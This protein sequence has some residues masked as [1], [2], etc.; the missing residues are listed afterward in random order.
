MDTLEKVIDMQKEGIDDVEISIKLQNEG[1]SP[2]EIEDSLNQ[3][4]VK[5]AVSPP[6]PMGTGAPQPEA[7][8]MHPPAQ[9][10][11]MSASPAQGMQQSIM[12]DAEQGNR[13]P[14]PATPPAPETPTDPPPA[15]QIEAPQAPAPEV[16]PSQD[17][18]QQD[19]YYPETQFQ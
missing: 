12:T 18:G 2:R 17:Q 13:A 11:Q 15:P 16:Y 4:R 6:D 5:N 19:Y 7:P 8:P 1:V 3:A 10:P 14:I 9:P